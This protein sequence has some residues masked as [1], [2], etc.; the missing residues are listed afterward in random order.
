MDGP[1]NL[2]PYISLGLGGV[3]AIGQLWI[4]HHILSVTLPEKDKAH[5]V[6]QS[7]SRAAFLT[8]LNGIESKFTAVIERQGERME[9]NTEKISEGLGAMREAFL[10]MFAGRNKSTS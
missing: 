7:E 6:Q 5:A 9:R 2:A 8:S 3:L 1:T 4:I 10:G